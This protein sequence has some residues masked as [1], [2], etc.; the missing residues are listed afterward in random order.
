[1]DILLLKAMPAFIPK[2]RASLSNTGNAPGNPKQTGQTKVLASAPYSLAQLQ[3][4]L[5]LVASS[6]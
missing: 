5:C 2:S 3:K 1:L 6:T 4:I